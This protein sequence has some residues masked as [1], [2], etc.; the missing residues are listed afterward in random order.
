MGFTPG[1]PRGVG[2]DTSHDRKADL[3]RGRRFA[4]LTPHLVPG[5]RVDP[6]RGRIVPVGTVLGAY[7]R[8]QSVLLRCRRRVELDLR[9]AVEAGYG[10][11][12]TG[13]L[14]ERLRCGH[15]QGCRLGRADE[16]AERPEHGPW[17]GFVRHPGEH[18]KAWEVQAAAA[19]GE[20]SPS[21]AARPG[22]HLTNVARSVPSSTRVQVCS[23]KCAP[24]D[25]HCICCRLA[26]RLPTTRLTVDST[27]DVATRSP[28][29][30]RSA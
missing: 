15:W 26:K 27:K 22:Y 12:P 16:D 21:L 13:W 17:Q 29:R 11:H 8:R 10:D 1:Y 25:D 28:W 2:D 20:P 30:R 19:G 18:H 23:T 4:E 14:V 6:I 5:W 9:G 3:E 24:R 7:Q